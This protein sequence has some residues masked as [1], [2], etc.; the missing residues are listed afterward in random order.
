MKWIN[1]Q[2]SGLNVPVPDTW[3]LIDDGFVDTTIGYA[4]K[5][6]AEYG[7]PTDADYLAKTGIHKDS[8]SR[9]GGLAI[10]ISNG[11]TKISRIGYTWS[12]APYHH[13]LI[14]AHE[15]MEVL[16]T[17]WK[18]LDV[19]DQLLKDRG[20]HINLESLNKEVQANLGALVAVEK[21]FPGFDREKL[22]SG[23]AYAP[24]NSFLKEA[25]KAYDDIRR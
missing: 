13:V 3:E 11:D 8:L 17:H 22:I 19:L 24:Y 6:Y 15:E 4:Q 21:G 10:M 9:S 18:K 16:I 2:W 23:T 7:F 14:P 25:I 12:D 20:K 1:L 5:I